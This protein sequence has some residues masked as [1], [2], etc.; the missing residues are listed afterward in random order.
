MYIYI[1]VWICIHRQI[2]VAIDIGIYIYVDICIDMG[3]DKE[4]IDEPVTRYIGI[5]V[6]RYADKGMKTWRYVDVDR[7]LDRQIYRYVDMWM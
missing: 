2:L 6:Y 4:H 1:Y 3:T 7:H 5:L